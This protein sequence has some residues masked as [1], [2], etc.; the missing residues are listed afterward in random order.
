MRIPEY[1]IYERRSL[2][3]I[4]RWGVRAVVWSLMGLTLLMGW[5]A[6]YVFD[7]VEPFE[8]FHSGEHWISLE[9]LSPEARGFVEVRW[10]RPYGDLAWCVIWERH[11]CDHLILV[12]SRCI[13]WSSLREEQAR[14][15][16]LN[17]HI[18]LPAVD[19]IGDTVIVTCSGE[20]TLEDVLQ[21]TWNP[22]WEIERALNRLYDRGQMTQHR[23]DE[24]LFQFCGDVPPHIKANEEPQELSADIRWHCRK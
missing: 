2:P 21:S 17:C 20:V 14:E 8:G 9:Q 11:P 5:W 19:Q 16:V 24:L 18:P 4:V 23:R 3:W 10:E 22:D 13:Y 6:K 15:L 12:G 1:E 7:N